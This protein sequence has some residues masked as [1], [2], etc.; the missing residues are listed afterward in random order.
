LNLSL[1]TMIKNEIDILPTFLGHI[2]RFFDG[3]HLLDHRSTDGSTTLLKSF[4]SQHPGWEYT[5]LDFA[6]FFQS[7]A[8]SH[9]VNKQ[10]EGGAEAIALLDADEFVLGP[11]RA[12]DHKLASLDPDHTGLLQWRNCVPDSFDVGLRADLPVWVSRTPAPFGKLVITRSMHE[13]AS[14]GLRLFPGNHRAS[15]SDERQV[16]SQTLGELYHVP[17]RSKRQAVIKAITKAL[18]YV[19]RGVTNRDA[20]THNFE[21]VDLAA[22]DQLSDD[23]LVSFVNAYGLR[24]DQRSPVSR[25]VAFAIESLDIQ[26]ADGCQLFAGTTSPAGPEPETMLRHFSAMLSAWG[27]ADSPPEFVRNALPI[28]RALG[29]KSQN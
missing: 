20:G 24:A 29:T 18:G 26:L 6:G 28:S 4:C 17:L 25:E 21:L 3:G 14:E 19:A 27:L 16:P 9:F 12:F 2:A 22:G 1:V 13:R 11:R 23:V 5:Y 7:E 10:F 15:Y 8:T